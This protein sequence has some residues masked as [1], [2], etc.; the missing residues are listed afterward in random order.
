MGG[1]IGFESKPGVGSMF[2]FT[3]PLVEVA[4][5]QVE[6]PKV[7]VLATSSEAVQRFLVVDD[8]SINRLLVRQILKNNW[9]N[10]ELVEADK[11]PQGARSLAST[12]L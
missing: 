4:A 10:C 12:A 5:P 2:W 11:R 6:A 8:H 3:L 1:H 7:K 9:K